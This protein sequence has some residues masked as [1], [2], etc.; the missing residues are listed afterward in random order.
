MDEY[1][2]KRRAKHFICKMCNEFRPDEPCEPSDCDWLHYMDEEPAANVAPVVYGRWLNFYG[3]YSTAECDDCG[4]LYEVSP[5]E[6]P[7]EDFFN[8]FKEFYKYCPHCGAKMED[9]SEET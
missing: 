6:N 5:E 3:D 4:E 2:A 8:A 7:S 9:S 1:I